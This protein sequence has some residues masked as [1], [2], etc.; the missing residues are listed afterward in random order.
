MAYLALSGLLIAT[1]NGQHYIPHRWNV[2]SA[3]S[4]NYF[5]LY[6]IIVTGGYRVNIGRVGKLRVNKKRYFTHETIMSAKNNKF[7]QFTS[8]SYNLYLSDTLLMFQ[9]DQNQKQDGQF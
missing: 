7:M 1:G 9:S 4:R 2:Y 3:L 8:N 6:Y 5:T